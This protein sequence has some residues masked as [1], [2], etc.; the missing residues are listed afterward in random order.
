M[1]SGLYGAVPLAHF[2]LSFV[3]KPGDVA[4]DATCGNGGD[5]E[6]LARLVGEKGRVWAFDIQDSAL[7]TAGERLEG[8]RL[9]ERVTFVQAGHERM[10]EYVAPGVGAVVFNLGYLP[11]AGNGVATSAATTVAALEAGAKLLRLGGVVTIALYT[12]HPS[13]AAEAQ[14]VVAWGAGLAPQLFNVWQSRQLNRSDVAPYVVVI[15]RC[16]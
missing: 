1:R 7:R 12:G 15:E 16:G 8:A 6:L 2:Y 11:G 9:S 14:A 13:G 5:T 10:A 3:L 4:V